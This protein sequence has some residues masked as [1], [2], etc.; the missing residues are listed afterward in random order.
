MFKKILVA[1]DGSE[2]SVRALEAGAKLARGEEAELTV[3]TASY[4]PPLYRVDL[5]DELEE[6]FRDSAKIILEDARRI[7]ERSG[8]DARTVILEGQPGEA[9]V[10]FASE[11][12]FD[13]VVLGRR[14]LNSTGDKRL[15]GVSD[16]VLRKVECSVMLVH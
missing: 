2:H 1:I 3:A 12:E 14:G 11:G 10:G 15:G 5:G 16:A 13:L 4:V 6:S 9:V 8:S 7:L